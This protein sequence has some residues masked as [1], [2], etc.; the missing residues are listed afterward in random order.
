MY[1]AIDFGTCFSSA[2]WC[3]NNGVPQ[4]VNYGQLLFLPSSILVL[5]DGTVLSI[6]TV[7]RFTAV[8]DLIKHRQKPQV[9]N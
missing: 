7:D 8:F 6:P 2:A 4:A 9:W 1:L 3:P 5:E